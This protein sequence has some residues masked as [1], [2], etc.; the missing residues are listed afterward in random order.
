MTDQHPIFPRLEMLKSNVSM[1]FMRAA[2]SGDTDLRD[3]LLAKDRSYRGCRADR[4]GRIP[5][6]DVRPDYHPV[7]VSGFRVICCTLANRP[8]RFDDPCRKSAIIAR[9]SD[10]APFH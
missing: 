2:R 9:N 5:G 10:A 4:T 6:P 3:K 1:R 7:A 8:A